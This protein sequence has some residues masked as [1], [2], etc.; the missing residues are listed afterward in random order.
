MG[1]A[2]SPDHPDWQQAQQFLDA[3]PDLETIEVLITDLNGTQ[4]GKWIEPAKLKKLYGGDFKMTLTSVAQDIW[5]RDV[6]ALCTATG[7]GDG[8]IEPLTA[9]LKREPWLPR[10]TAQILMQLN[11][12]QGQPWGWDPR[13]VLQQVLARYQERGWRPV[14]A[15]EM[16]FYLF[17]QQRGDNGE[18]RIPG[19][20]LN[21]QCQIGGQIYSTELLQENADLLYEIRHCCETMKLPLDGLLKE[22]SPGQFE[23]NLFHHDDPL[24]LADDTQTLKRMIKGV[25]YK[26]GLC[27]SFIAKPAAQLAGNGMHAH[28]SLLDSDGNNLFNDGTEQGSDL[29]RHAI[30]GL[31][32]TMADS[33]LILAPHLNSYRRIGGVHTPQVP[34]WGYENRNAT[35]RV[36][37]GDPAARRIEYRLAGADSNI[38]LV[39]ATILAGALYGIDN[40]LEPEPPAT[41]YD[42]SQISRMRLPTNWWAALEQFEHSSFMRDY[43]GQP[44]VDAFCAVKKFEQDEFREHISAL[45]YDTYLATV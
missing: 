13:V 33:M 38:Y 31:A 37:N 40:Q 16:E 14:M 25:A 32:E 7:D 44:F 5:G 28:F 11:D 39:L 19:T 15:P 42:S 2:S 3:N 9:S 45:E 41:D 34:S 23:L 24:Q 18:P 27:A 17:E 21:G 30:A 29:L 35:L 10:P 6:D 43:L 1:Q 4:R 12:E 36:P 20:R 26:H 8:L 22:L